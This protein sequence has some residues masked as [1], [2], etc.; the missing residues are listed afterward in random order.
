MS[1]AYCTSFPFPLCFLQRA[2]KMMDTDGNGFFNS[3]EFRNVLNNLGTTN[4]PLS[5]PSNV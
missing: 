2:F 5:S 3:Y 4:L 1:Y